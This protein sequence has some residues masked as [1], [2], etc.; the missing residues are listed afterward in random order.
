M[1]RFHFLLCTLD[2]GGIFAY[3][4]FPSFPPDILQ[5]REQEYLHQNLSYFFGGKP[6]LFVTLYVRSSEHT[7]ML[8]FLTE[9]Y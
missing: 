7:P 2:A 6:T 5:L 1:E 9:I 3:Y 4:S 8:I